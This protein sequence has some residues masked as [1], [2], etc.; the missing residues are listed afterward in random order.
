NVL[1]V[2]PKVPAKT[3]QELTDYAHAHP[4]QLNLASMGNGTSGHLNGELFKLLAKASIQHVP[5]RG[6][7]PALTDLLGGRVQL[8]F[9]NLPTALPQIKSG[10]LRA[11]AVTSSE[12]SSSLPDVP[13]MEE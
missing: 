5:Y 3:V 2:N 6:S 10:Q 1:L 8:M 12:R 9:D 7:A 11:L 4:D 13:T